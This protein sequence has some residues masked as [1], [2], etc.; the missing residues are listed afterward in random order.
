MTREQLIAQIRQKAS[1]LCV[2][3]DT[4]PGRLPG[5][6]AGDPDAVL[7]F[8]RAIIDATAPYAVAYKPNTAFYET[9]GAEGWRQLK[10]TCRYIKTKYP[11]IMLIVDAKRGDIGNTARMYASAIFNDLDADAVTVAPYMGRD[12]VEPFLGFEGKWTI[13]LCLTSN[14]GSSDFQ[15]F[16]DTAGTPLYIE[17][18]KKSS[19]WADADRMMYVV[20]A[21]RADQLGDIRAAA[22]RSFLLVPGVGAQGGS[23]D[24]V[25][26][27]G[28]NAD[29]GLIVNSSRGI[30]FASSGDDYAKVAAE[31]AR[32][33]Q[34]AMAPYAR[35]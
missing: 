27:F 26:R 2:G 24:D 22:P 25:C 8:N 5:C 13:L 28:L 7:T 14:P 6:L 31:K 4:D 17:V 23:L 30:I 15:Y 18:L 16:T 1:F 21:T 20:G 32:E 9:R 11:E 35:P 34:Q 19:Q 33:L 10:E 29:C 12:S 3:L